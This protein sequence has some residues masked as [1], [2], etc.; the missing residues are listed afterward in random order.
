MHI[1]NINWHTLG[2]D[3]VAQRLETTPDGL[4]QEQ[5]AERLAHYG[6]NELREKRARSSWRMLLDQFSDFM[7]I[8]LIIAAIISGIVGDIEDTVAIIVIVI[9]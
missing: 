9:L 5:A 1:D 3:Q 7:I 4:S 6:A 8:V 2:T